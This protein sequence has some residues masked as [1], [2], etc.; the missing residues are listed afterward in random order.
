M[1]NEISQS[2]GVF[3]VKKLAEWKGK[4]VSEGYMLVRKIEKGTGKDSLGCEV[5]AQN[6]E[7]M[8]AAMENA[9]VFAAAVEWFQGAWN[10]CLKGKLEEGATL[11]REDCA[12]SVLVSYLE[13]QE[14]AAGRVSK[15][16]IAAWFDSSVARVVKEAVTQKY[17]NVENDKMLAVLKNYK[18]QFAMLA[19]R[20]LSLSSATSASLEKVLELLSEDDAMVKYCKAKIVA[21]PEKTV[22]M[23]AL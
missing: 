22:D 18:D 9:V 12:L 21:S 4:E 6:G 23:L 20:E 5:P 10:D 11:L 13:A 14:V 16:K 15:E 19:K 1:A 7:Q 3:T 8:V 17:G 2:T